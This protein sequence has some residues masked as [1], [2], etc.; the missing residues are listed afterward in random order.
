[1][2]LDLNR[3]SVYS[4]AAE[5]SVPDFAFLTVNFMV[6]LVLKGGTRHPT[7]VVEVSAAVMGWSGTGEEDGKGVGVKDGNF[8]G[9]GADDGRI[10]FFV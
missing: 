3:V 8:V 2:I 10:V 9:A 4:L 6:R 1:M 7:E 5:S